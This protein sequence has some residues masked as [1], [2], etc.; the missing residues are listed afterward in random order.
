MGMHDHEFPG[1]DLPYRL[2][3]GFLV[4][5]YKPSR[6]SIFW[7]FSLR[8]PAVSKRI[9]LRGGTTKHESIE[10]ARR[11]VNA[12]QTERRRIIRDG[13]ALVS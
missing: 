8:L 2:I 12:Y 13:V 10:S 6:R 9:H 11:F 5:L 3:D 7:N 4:C 1:D